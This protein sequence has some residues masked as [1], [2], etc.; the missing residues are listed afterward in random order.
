MSNEAA[1]S[2]G[3]MEGHGAYNRHA[4]LPAGG[5]AMALPSLEKAVQSLQIDASD[6]PVVIADYGSS[7]GKNSMAPMQAAI[8]GLRK[9]VGPDRAISVF[10]VDQPSNDFGSLFEVLHADPD[11]YVADEPNVFPA[12]I[13]R[14]FYENVL[15]PASVHLGWSSYAAVWLSRV[16]T[17]IPG[18]FVSP[19]STGTVRAQFERQ[20]EQDWRSFLSLRARE[21]R[22]GARLVVALPA[23]ADDGASGLE[24]IFDQANVVLG[25]LVAEGAITSEERSSMALG[26]HPR[27]NRDLLAPFAGDGEFQ[28]LT[29]EELRMFEFPDAAWTDYQRDGDKEALAAKQALFFRSIFVPSLGAALARV[30]AGDAEALGAFGDR[31]EQ[32]LKQRLVGQPASTHSFVQVMVLAKKP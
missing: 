28:Q 2:H 22:P 11:R 19:H 14:S 1:P 21:L 27:R 13:G 8:R 3:V 7:Q 18:H 9:R 10:H 12:A 5:A 15:P 16:P 20:G 26:S 24:P 17:L 4:R 25:D 32:R 6:Q 29:V 23:L 30:R 31:L